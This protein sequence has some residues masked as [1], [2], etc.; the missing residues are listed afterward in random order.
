MQRP[1]L[2]L[3]S[4]FG[5]TPAGEWVQTESVK[6][7][8]TFR[9]TSLTDERVVYALVVNQQAKYIGVCENEKTTLGDR[10]GRY[11]NRQGAGQNKRISARILETLRAGQSVQIHALKPASSV[12]YHDLEVDLV[13]GLENPLIQLFKPEWNRT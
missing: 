9:L 13:K 11:K 8:I 5:F 6:S 4:S 7:G 1:E 12:H 3:L 2:P 10:M